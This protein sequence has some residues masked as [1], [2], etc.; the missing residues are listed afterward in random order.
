MKIAKIVASADPA[1][2]PYNCQIWHTEPDS[3]ALHYSGQGLF[4]KTLG[5]AYAYAR[6]QGAG[7]TEAPSLTGEASSLGSLS[8]RCGYTTTPQT[9]RR[10]MTINELIDGV[11]HEVQGPV[12]V[13]QVKN[14][15][16]DLE[17]LFACDHG[18]CDLPEEVA[19]MEIACIYSEP[20]GNGDTAIIFDVE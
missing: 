13:R 7:V 14:N 10:A 15:G 19:E 2:Y 3:F 4:C 12:E 5:E 9:G 11:G 6:E 8:R 16:N 17:K 18:F 20:W 1:D